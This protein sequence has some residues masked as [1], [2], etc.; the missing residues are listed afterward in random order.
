DLLV[1]SPRTSTP[2]P[3]LGD[4]VWCSWAAEEVYLFSARQ[5]S[6]VMA[7]ADDI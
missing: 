5:A 3:A 6:V 7:E 1:L 4:D 2:R